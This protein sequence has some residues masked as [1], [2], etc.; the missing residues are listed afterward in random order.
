[1]PSTC[2]VLNRKEDIVR[3]IKCNN[4][5]R[6]GGAGRADRENAKTVGN[7]LELLGDFFADRHLGASFYEKKNTIES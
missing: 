4:S 5:P 6:L 7:V 1:M 2:L 3:C